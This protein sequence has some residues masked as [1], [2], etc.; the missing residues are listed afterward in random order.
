MPAGSGDPG[1][2]GRLFLSVGQNVYFREAPV[3]AALP[4]PL[5][6][7]FLQELPVFSVFEKSHEGFACRRN[8]ITGERL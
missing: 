2:I 4:D 5:F 8:R 1:Y 7:Q 3:L 6:M